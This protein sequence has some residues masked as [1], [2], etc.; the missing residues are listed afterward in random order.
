MKLNYIIVFFCSMEERM[1]YRLGNENRIFIF[2]WP[3]PLRCSSFRYNLSVS[4]LFLPGHIWKWSIF[5]FYNQ[6]RQTSCFILLYCYYDSLSHQI[7]EI[8]E[9]RFIMFFSGSKQA[10]WLKSKWI[11]IKENINAGYTGQKYAKYA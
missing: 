9:M 5:P 7:Y 8:P 11:I 6:Y 4:V 1:S 10:N 2:D 3:F